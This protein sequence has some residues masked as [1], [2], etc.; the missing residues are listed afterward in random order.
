MVINWDNSK[1]KKDK[2]KQVPK[3]TEKLEGK[4]GNVVGRG[5]RLS[6]AKWEDKLKK[7]LCFK[8]GDK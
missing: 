2:V 6:S 3:E 7:G 4:E 5:R 8:C 1:F